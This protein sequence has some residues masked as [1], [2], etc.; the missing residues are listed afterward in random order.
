MERRGHYSLFFLFSLSP[1]SRKQVKMFV[2]YARVE[3][4]NLLHILNKK[5]GK[6]LNAVRI[7]PSNS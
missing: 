5:S 1:V 3:F 6:K 4:C 7:L 2:R